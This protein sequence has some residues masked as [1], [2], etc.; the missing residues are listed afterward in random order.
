M[1]VVDMIGSLDMYITSRIN[2]RHYV[3]V[4]VKLAHPLYSSI[5]DLNYFSLGYVEGY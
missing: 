1:A 5:V 2:R 4:V 3:I